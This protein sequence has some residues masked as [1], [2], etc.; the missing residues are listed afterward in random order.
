MTPTTPRG[1]SEAST[2]PADSMATSVPAPMAMPTS[3]RARAGASF[4]PSPTMATRQPARLQLGD[5]CGPCPR[6]APRR[7]PRRRRARRRRP[8]PPGAASPV[9]MTT[10]T[11][12]AWSS[13]HRLAGLGP[14]LVLE[15]ER[16]DDRAVP[17]ARRGR[18]RPGAA[19]PRSSAVESAGSSSV[20]LAQQRR[21]RRR[22]RGRRRRS[23]RRRGRSATGS[24]SPRATGPRGS[25]GRR[26]WP[27][28]AG[29]RCRPRPRRP[30]RSSA[31][32][33]RPSAAATPVTDVLARGEGAGLVEQHGVDRAH[34]LQ[35]E[36][37]LH[38]DPGAGRQRRRERDDQRDG[39]PEGVRAGDHQHRD[40]ALDGLVA[41]AEQRPDD[42]GDD[43]GRRGDV[44]QQ[45]GGP[46]GQRL[47]PG[48]RGLRLAR[49]AAGCRR[50]RSRRRPPSTRTRMAESVATVPA[51]TRSPAAFGTGR[52]S[53]VIID[54]STSAA[55]STTTPS[56]G[57]RA[58]GP[59]QHDV[60]GGELG[61]PGPSRR[62]RP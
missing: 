9:I 26:R 58:A 53:P 43:A 12:S 17:R 25:R 52:D 2:T 3:A 27:G 41:V 42:E 60:A 44:E 46:V 55:P 59:H 37:V 11:P 14:D 34:P 30:A 45:R 35:R 8:R 47:R 23:P 20:R 50:A 32:P 56:A 33:R 40:R 1:S 13:S 51:T 4:T 19:T 22:R 7:T 10:R 36:P 15:R 49:P 38:Q 6:A 16:A 29:A 48:P 54:S 24:R 18:R 21:A 61:R 62:R 28:P 5:R 31:R 39:Q 57:T